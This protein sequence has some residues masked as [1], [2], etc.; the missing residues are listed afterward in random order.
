MNIIMCD[1][2]ENKLAIM[3]WNIFQH[4]PEIGYT[5]NYVQGFYSQGASDSIDA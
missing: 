5:C 4:V 1:E 3:K 2:S